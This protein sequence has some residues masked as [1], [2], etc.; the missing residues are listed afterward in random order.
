[1]RKVQPQMEKILGPVP[2]LMRE[3]IEAQ[4][5]EAQIALYEARLIDRFGRWIPNP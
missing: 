4:I 2:D 5:R 3:K 1:M